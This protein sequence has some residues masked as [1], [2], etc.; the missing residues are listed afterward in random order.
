AAQSYPKHLMEV[1][2]SD[3]GSSDCLHGIE[4]IF[5]D[6]INIKVI[7]H[8]RHGFRLATVRN[9]GILAAKGEVIVCLDCDI[10]P[11]KECI[12]A[13]M[14][15]FHAADNVA[16]IGPRKFIDTSLVEAADVVQ[17][18]PALR[19]FADVASVSNRGKD[20]DK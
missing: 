9:R 2:V 19:Q 14:R 3:D 17:M 18:L 10:I 20:I 13:H 1:I 12:E 16:T 11:V 6:L 8:T 5:G 4:Q 7:T 15:W